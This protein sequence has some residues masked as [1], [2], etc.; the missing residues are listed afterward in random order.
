MCCKKHSFKEKSVFFSLYN[1]V[2]KP[3]N[4]K[5]KQHPN[6]ILNQGDP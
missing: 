6:E 5:I 4:L 3:L 2:I 1:Q